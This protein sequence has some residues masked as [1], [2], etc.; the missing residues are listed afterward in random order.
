MAIYTCPTCGE[1]MERDLSL[2]I[3]HTDKHI[4]AE[5]QKNNPAWVTKEGFCPKCLEY[6]KNQISGGTMEGTNL[7]AGGVLRRGALGILGIASGIGVLFWLR[8]IEAPPPARLFVF[9]LFFFGVLGFAQA[10]RKLCVVIAQKQAEAMR[11]KARRILIF[12]V[13]LSVL[14]TAA[15]YFL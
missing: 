2:F 10:K 4:V 14:L 13:L 7:D 5:L 15:G 12:A 11:L 9:P 6:Y 1:K 8:D 3:D